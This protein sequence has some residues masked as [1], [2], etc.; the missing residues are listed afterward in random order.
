MATSMAVAVRFLNKIAALNRGLEKNGIYRKLFFST[1]PYLGK[2]LV[3]TS[4]CEFVIYV[5]N[6]KGLK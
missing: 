3:D 6:K 2:H 1:L 4:L 5:G